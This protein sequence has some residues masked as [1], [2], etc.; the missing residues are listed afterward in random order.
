MSDPLERRHGWP[1]A[2][3][4]AELR[5][6]HLTFPLKGKNVKVSALQECNISL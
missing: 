3:F 4:G 2:E 1:A 5:N 6:S